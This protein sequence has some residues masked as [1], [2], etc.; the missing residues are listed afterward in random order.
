M[1]T[2]CVLVLN[3]TS[4]SVQDISRVEREDLEEPPGIGGL[5]HFSRNCN[6]WVTCAKLYATVTSTV[7]HYDYLFVYCW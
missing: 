1:G 7:T 5:K 6:V 3:F 2:S 4:F